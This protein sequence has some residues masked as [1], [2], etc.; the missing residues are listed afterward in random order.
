MS[1]QT[2]RIIIK[3]DLKFVY[4]KRSRKSVL[5]EREDIV[6]WRRRDLRS[7]R[8][9]RSAHKKNYYLDET[10]VNTGHTVSKIWQDTTITSY[11]HA[12]VDGLSRGLR[13]P[14]GKGQRLTVAHIGSESGFLEDSALIFLSKKTG[15]YHEDMEAQRF[16]KWFQSLLSR[17][18]PNSII[19][20]DNASYHSRLVK[21]LPTMATRKANMQSWLRQKGIPFSE[22]MVKA[23]LINV[24]RHNP[25][26]DCIVKLSKLLNILTLLI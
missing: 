21:H 1:K 22:D 18:E 17:V 5:I 7:I 16:E 24:I 25:C 14:T 12:F 2:L 6:S 10:W 4:A 19:V 11:R 3:E 9:V 15:D 26:E 23:E 8:E 20:M 13:G